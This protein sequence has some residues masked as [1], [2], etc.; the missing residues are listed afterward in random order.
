[1]EQLQQEGK[2][3]IDS[4]TTIKDW[5]KKGVN[6]KDIG[7]TLKDPATFSKSK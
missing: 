4:L 5:P 6:F 7:P 1:M 2:F 3:I